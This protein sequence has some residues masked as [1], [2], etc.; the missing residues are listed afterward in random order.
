MS[1]SNETE[2]PAWGVLPVEQYLIRKWDPSSKLNPDEQRAALL[3][4]Y[5]DEDVLDP[6][7]LASPPSRIP[8]E[9]EIAEILAPWRPQKLRCIAASYVV[10]NS[11]FHQWL[12][13]RTYYG[14]GAADDAKLRDWLDLDECEGSQ[15]QPE[16]EW[17][18]VLD[19]PALFDVGDDWQRVYTLLPELAAR[20]PDRRFTDWHV[21]TVRNFAAMHKKPGEGVDDEEYEDLIMRY[22]VMGSAWLLVLDEDAF[23]AGEFGLIMRDAKGNPVKETTIKPD[24]LQ[25]FYVAYAIK[26]SIYESEYWQEIAVGER[27]WTGGKIMGEL[28][29][30]VKGE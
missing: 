22:A 28:L 19:D 9:A 29:A 30:R 6:E 15:I 5:I 24:H 23:E 13:L 18:S 25:Y 10:P 14:G 7:L 12:I 17:H 27:Y 8:T 3:A 21:E 20:V 26:G 2:P 16:D 4:A 11:G 1:T